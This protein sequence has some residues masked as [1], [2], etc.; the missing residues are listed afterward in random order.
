[1]T[2][3]TLMINQTTSAQNSNNQK[4]TQK[5]A[6]RTLA[7]EVKYQRYTTLSMKIHTKKCPYHGCWRKPV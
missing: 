4:M 3:K 6:E 1:M 5:M 2:K 7:P